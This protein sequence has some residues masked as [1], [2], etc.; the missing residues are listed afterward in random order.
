MLT[1]TDIYRKT[2]P[3]GTDAAGNIKEE[4]FMR[5]NTNLTAMNTYGQ[6]TKNNNKI[7]SAVAKLSSGYAINAAADNAAGLAISEK[8]RAQIRG[9]Q[10]ASANAQD[11]ISLIQT[12]EGALEESTQIL[13]RMRELAVQS[14]SDSN[15]TIDRKALQDEFAQ[16]QKELNDIAKNTTFNKKNLLDGSLATSKQSVGS[17]TTLSGSSMSVT[18]GNASAGIYKFNVSVVTT[19][20]AVT[21]SAADK[22]TF[23]TSS[24]NTTYFN[25]SA[26][27]FSALSNAT[28][29]L[30]NGNYT[31]S[32]GEIDKEANTFTLVAT[33]DNGQVFTSAAIDMNADFSSD[34]TVTINFG[35]DAF[36]IEMD[37]QS[38]YANN[39]D[40]SGSGTEIGDQTL[41]NIANAF[42]GTAFTVS[43]GKDAKEAVTELQASLT[44]ASN[45]TLKAG[46]DSVTFDNGITVKFEK[47][48]SSD[49]DT[50]A[51]NYQAIFGSSESTIH[52]TS[53]ANAG[54]TFQVG[55]NEGDELTINIDRMDSEF[56]GINGATVIDRESAAAAVTVVDKAIN[57]VS[58]Q[59]AYLGAIQNRLDHKIAN[60]E[61]ST[62]NLTS[63]ESQIRDVDM[64]KEMTNFTNAN[65][66]QQAATAMLAQ[67]NSLP[68]NVLSLIGG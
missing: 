40:V 56:L 37:L 58:S 44:G 7:A 11:A 57:Q 8:M 13:Q 29:S 28:S 26:A 4:R 32:V 41:E 23:N 63:A 46:D 9:L 21:A 65:I 25:A 5:I 19:Q 22:L 15:E 30:L 47:L 35:T 31:L 48:T 24:I 20:N 60:L 33:G 51:T 14:A 62:E 66:L 27:T 34:A 64:A 17:G 16:L 52:I 53:T 12:A 49:V 18:A 43:G 1:C 36:T 68:Q 61:T 45:V 59:R 67:A 39:Y 38:A 6:Y 3:S 10:K 42:T 2:K 55:A 54:L 50:K